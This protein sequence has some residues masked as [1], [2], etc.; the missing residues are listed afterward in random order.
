MMRYVIASRGALSA[1]H[2]V[3][4]R[5]CGLVGLDNLVPRRGEGSGVSFPLCENNLNKG[6][7]S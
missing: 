3:S 5:R 6:G 1:L 4:Y 2:S 7:A